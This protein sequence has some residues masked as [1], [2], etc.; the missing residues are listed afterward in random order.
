[1]IFSVPPFWVKSP[2]EI[3]QTVNGHS[4]ELTCHVH[5]VPAPQI[6]WSFAK[7][8]MADKYTNLYANN[9]TLLANQSLVISPVD[10]SDAGYYQCEASNGVGNNINAL[11]A[12]QVHGKISNFPIPAG[13]IIMTNF[14][15][16]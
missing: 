6:I 13:I 11:I 8:K 7:E 15:F 9:R 2:T 3:V 16:N 1:M 5:G 14:V 4:V 10:M 12:L